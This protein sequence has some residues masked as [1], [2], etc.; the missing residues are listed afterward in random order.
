MKENNFIK[1][2]KKIMNE[3]I[4]EKFPT[5]KNKE[6]RMEESKEPN[7]SADAKRFYSFLRIRITLGVRK[8]DKNKL[9]GLLAHEL[10]HL[11]Y[12]I[13]LSWFHYE[14]FRDFK[15]W[16]KKYL[17]EDEKNTDITVIK[18]GYAR[19]LY[20]QRKSVWNTKRARKLRWKYLS[21]NE[22][23]DIA[24]KLKKW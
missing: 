19:Q 18:K 23:K 9:I 7:G 21:P 20:L 10:S 6:I 1:K 2:Y 8:Y 24:I 5:L 17:K 4:S 13:T 16:F 12:F 22:V 14:I 11:E 15:L 3:L